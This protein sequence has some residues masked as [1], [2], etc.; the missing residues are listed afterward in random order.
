MKIKP[1]KNL[2]ERYIK[3][4]P[5][6][7]IVV[8]KEILLCHLTNAVRRVCNLSCNSVYVST[9]MLKHLYD[10]KP[11]EQYDFIIYN[12][13]TIVKYPDHIYKNKDGKRGDLILVKV[14]KNK[15]CLCSI[16]DKNKKIEIAT[17]FRV[18]DSYLNNYELL[19]SWRDDK[20]PS[21]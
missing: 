13:H 20:N 10:G 5:H 14:L 11:A 7:A 21:S 9:R 8:Q 18:K 16:E 3:R 2:H 12:L 6:N 17:A 15:K 4:T 1:L 19:W